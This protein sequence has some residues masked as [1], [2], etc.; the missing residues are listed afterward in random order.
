MAGTRLL[1]Q[2]VVLLE[3]LCVVVISFYVGFCH[4]HLR[5]TGEKQIT[6]HTIKSKD[7]YQQ[8]D[9][10]STVIDYIMNFFNGDGIEQQQ[11]VT[12]AVDDDPTTIVSLQ[13]MLIV[14]DIS[15]LQYWSTKLNEEYQI[16][17]YVEGLRTID[18]PKPIQI[19]IVPPLLE[20][21]ATMSESTLQSIWKHLYDNDCIEITNINENPSLII[22]VP[23]YI[24]N[25]KNETTIKQDSDGE[26][27]VV[28]GSDSEQ[29]QNALA[30][31][32]SSPPPAIWSYEIDVETS[33]KERPWILIPSSTNIDNHVKPIIDTWMMQKITAAANANTLYATTDDWWE[34]LYEQWKLQTK[35][36]Y[37]TL[38][39]LPSNISNG[40][41][42]IIE[43]SYNKTDDEDGHHQIGFVS[44]LQDTYLYLQWLLDNGIA[45]QRKESVDNP[46]LLTPDFPIEHYAAIFLPLLFPLL[47]PFLVSFMKEYIRWKQK[48]RDKDKQGDGRTTQDNDDKAEPTSKEKSS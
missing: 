19:H 47:V 33:N 5:P 21:K 6:P 14:E 10:C 48:K 28:D 9:L 38:D 22:Y 30:S 11:Y 1:I 13:M 31:K 36:L 15:Q 7:Y 29:E 27:V 44:R 43:D 12:K 23:S 18:I 26:Y 2:S 20:E 34:F 37:N 41:I 16:P 8:D 35:Q 39:D 3:L 46:L 45:T 42:E 40:I 4:R 17:S 32:E 24:T 25:K